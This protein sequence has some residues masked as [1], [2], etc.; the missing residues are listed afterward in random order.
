MLPVKKQ[1]RPPSWTKREILDGIF[2][3]LKNGCNWENL[4]T[5]SHQN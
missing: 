3:K 5:D 4:P 1:T 2:Y